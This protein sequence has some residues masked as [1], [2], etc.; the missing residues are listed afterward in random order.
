MTPDSRDSSSTGVGWPVELRGVTESI[1]ATLGPNDR[2]NL[3][4]LGLQG[5]DW[6]GSAPTETEGEETPRAEGTDGPV[7][8]RTWGRTRTRRNFEREG[9]GVVQFTR[10]PLLFVDAA[11]GIEER[12][13]PVD[14]GAHAWVRV[15]TDRIATGESG[16]TEWADWRL[17]PT[18]RAV[19]RR[20][21]PTTR[22]GHAAVVEATVAASR[23]D[24]DAYDESDL[25]DRLD[26]LAGVVDRCGDAREVAAF[27]R[28]DEHVCWT[29]R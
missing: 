18:R 26:H 21:V 9:E 14:E 4:A 10:D 22:R 28:V 8:A 5:P 27:E 23:L 15:A 3:A 12:S 13:D 19:V 7:T 29:D 25:L 17:T 2:W 1:V 16:G 24:V 20:T 11:L 6:A